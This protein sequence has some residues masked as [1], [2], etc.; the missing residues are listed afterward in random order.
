MNLHHRTSII[1]LPIIVLVFHIVLISTLGATIMSSQYH[2]VTTVPPL[3]PP[4]HN[5]M[6]PQYDHYVQPVSSSCILSEMLSYSYPHLQHSAGKRWLD[7]ATCSAMLVLAYPLFHFATW[8]ARE[9]DGHERRITGTSVAEQD[10]ASQCLSAYV[11]RAL[12]ME[13]WQN[14]VIYPSR[15]HNQW[16]GCDWP[17]ASLCSSDI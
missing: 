15:G 12:L 5:I 7:I 2:H 4:N 9:Y 8:Y 14:R 3:C 10:S 1:L 17:V 11:G 13:G 6:Y 16:L